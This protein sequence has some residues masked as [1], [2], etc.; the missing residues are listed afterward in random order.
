MM[1][2]SLIFKSKQDYVS[3]DVLCKYSKKCQEIF[4]LKIL[5][6]LKK[7]KLNNILRMIYITEFFYYKTYF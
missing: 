5:T 3:D 7:N 2:F 1:V 6:H 4:L